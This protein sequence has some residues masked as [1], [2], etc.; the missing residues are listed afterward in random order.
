[1]NSSL[2]YSGAASS[3]VGDSPVN[4]KQLRSP[5]NIM[6]RTMSSATGSTN[7]EDSE[8][9]LGN[10]VSQWSR[11][12]FWPMH[13]YVSVVSAKLA[14]KRRWIPLVAKNRGYY[15]QCST[16]KNA[17]WGVAM[18]CSHTKKT[19]SEETVRRELVSASWLIRTIRCTMTRYDLASQ[20]HDDS[21]VKT[22]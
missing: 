3:G 8:T 4:W 5:F 15:P 12:P 18:F 9:W 21:G 20:N 2:S 13:Q 19:Q 17:H 10:R 14:S 1:M 22:T 7:L 6:M 16:N 11:T